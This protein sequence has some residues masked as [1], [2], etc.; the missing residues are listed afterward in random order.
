MQQSLA[1]LK[2]IPE[3]FAKEKDLERLQERLEVLVKPQLL[4]ALEAHR[5]GMYHL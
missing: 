5:V 4:K 1:I 2:D 3:F